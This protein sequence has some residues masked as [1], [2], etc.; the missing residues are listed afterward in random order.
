MTTSKW[1]DVMADLI[2]GVERELR[3]KAQ[4]KV[5]GSLNVFRMR[6][7]EVR[8]IR[9][10]K[11]FEQE[12][13]AFLR[14]KPFLRGAAGR[15]VR[16]KAIPLIEAAVAA[17]NEAVPFLAKGKRSSGRLAAVTGTPD[18]GPRTSD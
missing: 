8:T 4:I 18:S 9:T 12:L 7:K 11:Q 17:L 6:L 16:K 2:D 15:Y 1:K 3:S 13:E 10:R 5:E 14:S